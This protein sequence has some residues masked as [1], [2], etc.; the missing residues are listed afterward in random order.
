MSLAYYLVWGKSSETIKTKVESNDKYVGM[1][2]KLDMLSLL[3][4]IK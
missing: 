3:N 4:Y 1:S 2:R